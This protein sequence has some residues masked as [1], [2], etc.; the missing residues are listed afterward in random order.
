MKNLLSLTCVVALLCGCSVMHFQNGPVAPEGRP[1]ER[2]HHNVALSLYEISPPLDMNALCK[3]KQWSV[4]T[5]KETVVTGLAGA[6]V[7]S[8]AFGASIWDPQM[9]EYYCG[10]K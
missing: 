10:G 9:V 4:V 3:D 6:V 2:W 1:V 8:V 5:T 7:N